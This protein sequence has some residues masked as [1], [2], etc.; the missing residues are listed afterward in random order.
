M[1]FFSREFREVG[2]NSI[3]IRE[4]SRHSRPMNQSMRKS[5]RF[6]GD[7]LKEKLL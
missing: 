1:K 4:N 6:N 7:F 3:E 5:C 2:R